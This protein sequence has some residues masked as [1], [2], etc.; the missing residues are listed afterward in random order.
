M[1]GLPILL[2]GLLLA[3]LSGACAYLPGGSAPDRPPLL[4]EGLALPAGTTVESKDLR[5]ETK[6]PK[7]GGKAVKTETMQLQVKPPQGWAELTAHFVGQLGSHGFVEQP[8]D[9]KTNEYGERKHLELVNARTGETL[10]LRY[11]KL[12]RS[13]WDPDGA[14]APPRYYI[15]VVRELSR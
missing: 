2:A 1:T 3:L 8:E 4:I 6:Y 10:R 12:N 13:M 15:Q 9:N 14:E 5:I 7:G 11:L